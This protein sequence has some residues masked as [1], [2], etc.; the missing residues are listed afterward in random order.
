MPSL[1]FSEPFL[2]PKEILSDAEKKMYE[3]IEKNNPEELKQRYKWWS[4]HDIMKFYHSGLIPKEN[5]ANFFPF[6]IDLTAPELL[7]NKYRDQDLVNGFEVAMSKLK[8]VT[9]AI[10]KYHT[11]AKAQWSNT[12]TQS[13]LGASMRKGGNKDKKSKHHSRKSKNQRGGEEVFTVNNNDDVNVAFSYEKLKDQCTLS[14]FND[15]FHSRNRIFLV[16][17]QLPTWNPK[18]YEELRANAD[19]LKAEKATPPAAA[20]VAAAA[21]AA[22]APAAVPGAPAPAPAAPAVGGGKQRK[23][24][25]HKYKKARGKKGKSR[26][27]RK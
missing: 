17:N 19:K 15:V 7:Q 23:T 24:R 4:M 26:R 11:E 10:A 20:P 14:L 9:S 22:A 16:D 21:A 18:T 1:S 12:M 27:I 3:D 6:K 5:D 13:T 25:K 8:D 2:I